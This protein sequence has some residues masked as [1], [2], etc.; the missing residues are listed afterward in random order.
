MKNWPKIPIFL[1]PENQ[2]IIEFY[3]LK[4]LPYKRRMV[5][6]LTCLIMGLLFQIITLTTWPG[7]ILLILGASLNLI[8]GQKNKGKLKAY[9][10]NSNW[11]K[12]NMDRIHKINELKVKINKWD[13][14]VLDIS[15][16]MGC[17]AFGAVAGILLLTFIAL[18]TAKSKVAGIFLI[19]SMILV[20]SLWFNGMRIKEH[21]NELYIKADLIIQLESFFGKIKKDDENFI[22]SLLLSENKQGECFP[23][24][25]RFNITF[26]NMPVD[27]YGIQTQ[28]NINVVDTIYPYFYC[29][30]T[31]KEGFGLEKY[32]RRINAPKSIILQHSKDAEAEVIVIRQHTTKSSGYHTKI[33][34]C[35]NI[36][37][38]ALTLARLI[39][40]ENR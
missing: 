36:L 7:A 16:G 9:G 32:V 2:G 5:L 33:N 26:D 10:A 12:T 34:A 40:E 24:D 19:D 25:C 14:D 35:K 27:F 23:T 29:V 8:K 21:Q 3:F 39:N 38:L 30:I 11:V 1:S 6:Y 28:I 4:R 15:N 13:R 18:S 22:P 20:L 31:A 37:E 17:L